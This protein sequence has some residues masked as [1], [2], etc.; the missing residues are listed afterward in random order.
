MMP[1]PEPP[2][3]ARWLLGRAL[4]ADVR[5]DIAGDL[6][7]VFRRRCETDGPRRARLWYWTEAVSFSGRFLRERL[8]EWRPGRGEARGPTESSSV[9]R[10]EG[11]SARV[12]WLDFKLGLRMLIKY[13]GLT[14]VGGLAMSFGIALGAA[15]LEVVNDFRRPTIPLEDGDRIVGLRNWDLAANDAEPRSLHDFVVWRDELESVQDLGAFRPVE[16]NL[17]IDEHGGEPVRGAEISASAF[18]V[19]RV[20]PFLGRR[21]EDADEQA[22]AAPVVVIGYDV[23]QSRFDA[24]PE[25]VGRV[26]RLGNTP[27]TVVGVMPEGFAFPVN[28]HYWV[29]LERDIAGYERREGPSIQVFGRLAPGVT[30]QRA[31]AELTAIALRLAA[32]FPETNER[33]RPR[34]V[35]YT[36]LFFGAGSA[37]EL[38]WIESVL[39]MVLVVISANVATLVFARTA[40]RE[41]EIVVRYALGASRS[42]IIAQLFIEALVLGLAAALIGLAAVA[43]TLKWLTGLFWNHVNGGPAPFWWNDGLAP[44]TMLYAGAA[45]ALGA[46]LAG[47]LPALKATGPRVQSRLRHVADS[48]GSG[49]RFGGLWTG[50]IVTQVAFAVATLPFAVGFGWTWGG[51]DAE[52]ANLGFPAEEYLSARLEMR[53]EVP[54]SDSASRM[55]ALAHFQSTYQELR[56]RLEAEPSAVSVT[57]ADRLPGMRHRTRQVEVEGVAPPTGRD[58]ISIGEPPLHGHEV[59]AAFV[60]VNFFE[61]LGAPILSGRGFH[62]GDLVADSRAVIVNESFVRE[63]LLDRNAIGRRVRYAS[64]PAETLGPWYEIVGVAKE[65]ATERTWISLRAQRTAALYYPLAADPTL[66]L[67]GNP[68]PVAGR[69]EP[70]TTGP[71]GT[72]AVRM[73]VH[74]RDDAASFAARLRAA[75]AALDPTL[76]VYDVATLDGLVDQNSRLNQFLNLLIGSVFAVVALIGLLIS[77]A[78]TYSLMSFTV[79]CRSREIGIRTALGASPRRILWAVFSR[80]FMQIGLGVVVGI[81]PLILLLDAMSGSGPA[82]PASRLEQ[83]GASLTVV[84]IMTVVG[85]LACGVPARRALRIQPTEALKDVG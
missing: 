65:I 68:A 81:L 31:Q 28:Q 13:P 58:E 35:P 46:V 22:G 3:L 57:F 23:W 5:D 39:V 77:A 24:D 7:E 45:A 79:S 16:R 54:S 66:F 82:D 2:R 20:S 4:P 29:P 43:W 37:A 76:H 38:Y 53:W 12:S 26:V 32:E 62:S 74:V 44:A 19:A 80:A 56:R 69:T 14:L 52:A 42:R 1:R 85:L 60:D 6:D 30:L 71:S 83:L 47:V 41:G 10:G 17:I 36:E 48:G 18:D 50:M 63:I 15:Y 11:M 72:Y 61:A 70:V 33:L 40:T 8:R 34:I 78:G 73:A 25:V 49:M 75:A 84:T 51:A 21:L 59:E 9:R 55:A 64:P 27:T 67:A